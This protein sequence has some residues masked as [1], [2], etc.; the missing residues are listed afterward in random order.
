MLHSGR[1][2]SHETTVALRE[3]LYDLGTMHA[4]RFGELYDNQTM[5][6]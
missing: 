5:E 2:I 1:Y 6:Q 4:N 3:I